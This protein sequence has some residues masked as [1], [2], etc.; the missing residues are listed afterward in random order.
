MCQVYKHI[1]RRDV[2]SFAEPEK[3]RVTHLHLDLEVS[4]SRQ[5][6]NGVVTL[7]VHRMKETTEPL[8][9]DTRDLVIHTVERSEDGGHFTALQDELR[10][11]DRLLGCPLVIHLDSSD[12]FVRIAY[13]TS[14]QATA[15][16]WLDPPDC[17]GT[18]PV[19]VHSVAGNPRAKLVAAAGYAVGAYDVLGPN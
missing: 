14:A 15:L 17:F 5:Q 10:P 2:H 7:S 18:F 12:H 9:L 19:P 3:F 16:Q 6:L 13:T 11:R 1:Q 8:V 4:F